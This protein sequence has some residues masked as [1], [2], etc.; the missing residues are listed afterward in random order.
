MLWP[1]DFTGPPINQIRFPYPQI[2][3]QFVAV[4]FVC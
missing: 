4:G 2:S 3:R 1:G